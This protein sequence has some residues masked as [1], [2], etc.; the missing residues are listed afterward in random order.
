[1][2]ISN[3]KDA[4]KIFLLDNS[5]KQV[6]F[7]VDLTITQ[8]HSRGSLDASNSVL[9]EAYLESGLATDA[10]SAMHL[11]KELGLRMGV[12]TFQREAREGPFIGGT[13]LVKKV[14]E[15][16]GASTFISDDSIIALSPNEYARMVNS[17]SY[18][19]NR[20]IEELFRRWDMK[21][22]ADVSTSTTLLIDD[23]EQ[24]VNSFTRRGGYG[25]IACG[26]NGL[27]LETAVCVTPEGGR[28]RLISN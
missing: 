25:L 8:R 6:V 19:K 15:R 13:V 4:L 9:L 7:D 16:M 11:C 1:M 23:T 3:P 24:N 20:Q 2:S 10:L 27:K 14:L 5:I 21:D 12:V 26:G 18:D 17:T 28:R 22:S